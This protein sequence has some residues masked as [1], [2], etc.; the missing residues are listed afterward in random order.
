[1]AWVN[2]TDLSEVVLRL[3]VRRVDGCGN[4][5]TLGPVTEVATQRQ[6]SSKSDQSGRETCRM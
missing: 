5:L 1:M 3:Y 6:L 4:L 2:L